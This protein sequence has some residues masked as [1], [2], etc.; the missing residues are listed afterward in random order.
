M[1]GKYA[2]FMMEAFAWS[3]KLAL[4]Q[5]CSGVEA[6]LAGSDDQLYTKRLLP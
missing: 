3:L 5:T 1:T 2:L 6:R 4:D